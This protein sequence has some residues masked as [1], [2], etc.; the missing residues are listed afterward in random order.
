MNDKS[1]LLFGWINFVIL[2]GAFLWLLGPL[3]HH[4]FFARRSRIKK[5]MT[6]SMSMLRSAR[7]RFAKMRRLMTSLE[8]DVESR[9]KAIEEGCQK[10]CNALLLEARRREERIL[11]GADRQEEEDRARCMEMVKRRLLSEAFR[12]AEQRLGKGLSREVNRQLID[13]GV[14]ELTRQSPFG[15]S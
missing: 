13:R 11:K 5:E 7:A 15:L 1:S 12:R 6:I 4:F 9:K 3:A 8:E 2:V 10:E 14:A